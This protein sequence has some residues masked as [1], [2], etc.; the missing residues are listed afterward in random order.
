M[1]PTE[2]ETTLEYYLRTAP[3]FNRWQ[4]VDTQKYEAYVCWVLRD[5]KDSTTATSKQET[6]SL[7]FPG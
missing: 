7:R 3:K 4:E 2:T 5:N 6:V 1:T